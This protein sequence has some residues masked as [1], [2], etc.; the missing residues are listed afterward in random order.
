M[1][2]RGWLATAVGILVFVTPARVDAAC[3]I[4]PSV[5]K[6]FRSNLGAA[7]RPFA[8]PGDLVQVTVDPAGCDAASAGLAGGPLENVT[9]VFTPVGTA[10]RRIVVLATDCAAPEVV[11]QLAKCQSDSR[12]PQPVS[13]VSQPEAGLSTLPG[14]LTFRFP[15]TTALNAPAGFA[16]P[17][18]IAITDAAEPLP[19]ALARAGATCASQ[20]GLLACIDDLYTAEGSCAPTADERF[21]H[22]TATPPCTALATSARATFDTSGNVLMP[23]NWQGVLLS[24]AGVPVPRIVAAAFAPPVGFAIPDQVFLGSFTPEGQP[25]P[26]VFVPQAD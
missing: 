16:G 25:L 11:A 2:F 8:A 10:P 12:S 15:D 24:Q 20:T 4:I 18:T 3:N 6:I 22:F 9:I 1:M 23:M 5:S 26:P 17:A 19:C 13:C 14:T 7:N 21:P